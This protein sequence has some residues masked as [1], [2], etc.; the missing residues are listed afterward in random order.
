M[1]SYFPS[2]SPPNTLAGLI[3]WV[4][5]ELQNIGFAF[6]QDITLGPLR[7]V[8][9]EKPRDGMVTGADGDNWDPGAG[10]GYYVYYASQWN[11]LG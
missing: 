6:S 11:K 4:Y 5:R 1:P 10:A 9:P 7:A 3:Q 2:T 8:E